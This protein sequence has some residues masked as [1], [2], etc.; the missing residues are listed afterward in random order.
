MIRIILVDDHGL[1]CDG[2]RR[3]LEDA[4]DVRVAGTFADATGAVRFL[5]R[6]ALDV[7]LLAVGGD[8]GIDLA[9]RMRAVSPKTAILILSEDARAEAVR[10]ALWAG[11][12]GYLLQ[13]SASHEVLAA[14]R[15]VHAGRRYI[16]RRIAP[17]GRESFA[18]DPL[19]RLSAREMEVLKLVVEGNTS[20][21]VAARLGL[22]PKSIDTYRS[23]LM[24]KLE[25]HHLAG[26]VKFAIRRG[27][28]SP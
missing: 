11:A 13:E 25:V 17:A 9:R 18:P 4:A 1:V 27:L 20:A 21:E 2:V 3:L 7:V 8:G 10:Q 16:S 28:T 19:E 12:S 24:T 15:A 6:Q 26:L 5:A 22:S 14:L 23:R